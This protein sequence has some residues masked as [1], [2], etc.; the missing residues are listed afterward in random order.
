MVDNGLEG[1]TEMGNLPA[2]SSEAKEVEE[3]SVVAAR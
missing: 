3:W 2:L 1:G